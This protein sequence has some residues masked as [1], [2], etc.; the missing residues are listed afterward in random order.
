[1]TLRPLAL[2]ALLA[3]LA[4][5]GVPYAVGS[6][7]TTVAPR[8]V[9]PSVVLQVASA[10]R[11]LD[12]DEAPRAGGLSVGN[13]A[14]LGLDDRS[15]IGVRLLGLGTVAATYKRRLTGAA[16]GDRGAALLLGGGIVGLS[17]FHL[18]G[19]L[20]ASAGPVDPAG[21]VVPYGG[22]RVQDLTPFAD[23]ARDSSPAVGLFLGSRFGWP[24]LAIAPEIGVFYSPSDLARDDDVIVVPS[25]TVRGDR[26]RK[27][28]G[29]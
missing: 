17:H 18:E 14:R 27:A 7:P 9:E 13:E 12:R 11:D 8:E 2:A 29:L 21:R 28:L 19:T 4:G 6:T 3:S 20:V 1:M 5:C 15:D 23:D 25:V 22:V 26:L 10:K 24:D 16:G